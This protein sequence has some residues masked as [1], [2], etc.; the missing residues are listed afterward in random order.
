M[1]AIDV[2]LERAEMGDEEPVILKTGW[3]IFAG[4]GGYM[5][6][7]E[8]THTG[9]EANIDGAVMLGLAP[10][11]VERAEA[12]ASRKI[13]TVNGVEITRLKDGNVE[14]LASL[15]G[16][17]YVAYGWYDAAADY[18]IQHAPDQR[19]MDIVERLLALE[20][21]TRGNCGCTID[22]AA[23]YCAGCGNCSTDC[24]CDAIV[25]VPQAMLSGCKYCG[26]ANCDDGSECGGAD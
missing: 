24:T 12:I 5:V 6:E 4:D 1:M 21:V 11:D 14:F 16:K 10:E 7:F 23:G 18:G 13:A 8:R 15:G 25:S 19:N 3:T 17:T 2:A 9:W 20:C 22:K 26:C